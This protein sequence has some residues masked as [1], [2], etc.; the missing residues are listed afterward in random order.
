[1]YK[2]KVM[3]ISFPPRLDRTETM[4]RK[5]FLLVRHQKCRMKEVDICYTFQRTKGQNMVNY[6]IW[7]LI[8]Y[9]GLK[10]LVYLIDNM[11][12]KNPNIGYPK[13]ENK[14]C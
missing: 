12:I 13:K 3:H 5:Y 8:K 9:H 2:I 14:E 7:H 4:I 11:D 1:M 10:L 6:Q